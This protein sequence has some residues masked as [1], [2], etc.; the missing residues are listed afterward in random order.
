MESNNPWKKVQS[1][2]IEDSILAST[3][4]K[5]IL[6]GITTSPLGSGFRI[7]LKRRG[8]DN[9]IISET[10]SVPTEH[11]KVAKERPTEK[12]KEESEAGYRVPY[13]IHEDSL[14]K[15]EEAAARVTEAVY[16]HNHHDR[17]RK[18]HIYTRGQSARHR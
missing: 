6:A 14:R 4:T 12:N 9:T 5:Q 16:N 15:L 3:L 8:R 18:G 1:N 2:R 13:W 7:T 10:V 17:R 11:V